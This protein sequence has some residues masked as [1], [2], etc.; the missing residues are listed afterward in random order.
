[1]MKLGI[2]TDH[3]NQYELY[4]KSCKE[5]NVDYVVIDI[6]SSDWLT[7]IKA[8]IDCNGFIAR[9]MYDYEEQRDVYI[10]RIYYINNILKKIIYPTF[11]EQMIYENKRNMA[12]WLSMH[13]FPHV[14][15]KVFLRKQEALDFLNTCTYPLVIK[16]NLGAGGKGVEIIETKKKAIRRVNRI[17]GRIHHLFALGNPQK[18][19]KFGLNIPVYG[20]SQ[21]HV[22]IVQEYKEIKWEWRII[23]IDNSF[24]GHQKLLKG[25]FASGSGLVGWVEPPREL[26]DIVREICDRGNFYSMAVDIFETINDNYYVN[27]LQSLF[28]S[29][30]DSQMVID[31]KPGRFKYINNEYVFE[32]GEFNRFGS[33]LLRVEHFIKILKNNIEV[34]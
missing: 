23:K 24:F 14:E 5:L 4:E 20:M 29:F 32:D 2:L 21:K 12:T 31:G 25:K 19:K 18:R 9:P 7:N 22:M 6:L 27:E 26:L 11:D 1:M 33:C 8:N 3:Y 28:G 13:N 34:H 10:E 15:T 17:F 30:L 16:S